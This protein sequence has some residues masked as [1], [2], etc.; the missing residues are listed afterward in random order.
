VFLFILLGYITFTVQKNKQNCT[1]RKQGLILSGS[2]YA[3]V[4]S[5]GCKWVRVYVGGK[6]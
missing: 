2:R 6:K 5:E 4:D 3:P 1:E